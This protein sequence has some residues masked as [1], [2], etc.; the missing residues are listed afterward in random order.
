M[1]RT[2]APSR[3]STDA[4]LALALLCAVALAAWLDRGRVVH[5]QEAAIFSA[6]WAGIEFIGHILGI[7][8]AAVASSLVAVVSYLST[9]VAW[10][11]H[12]IAD[13][14][15]STGAVFAKVWEG[16]KIVWS[17]VL[18]PALVWIDKSITRLATWLKDTLKPVFKWLDTVR[19]HLD[20]IYKRFVRPI[21]DTIDFVRNV[22]RVLL[23]FHITL[24]QKL[25]SVLA[26][27]EQRIEE[28]ILWLYA[29]LSEVQNAVNYVV[30]ADGFFQRYALLRSMDKYAPA[31]MK[32]FWDKQV[33]GLSGQARID[34]AAREVRER[35][36]AEYG[37]H[38]SKIY[39]GHEG[40]LSGYVGE[41][42]PLWKDA[43]GLAT[44][45][46]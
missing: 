39:S 10:L 42:V 22:N 28:P 25:D 45:S 1:R 36:A 32:S 3:T 7:V 24:L 40:E 19:K 5:V 13:V 44:P 17:D 35:P 27:I 41:L 4:V 23:T 43:A 2:S 26:Q 9:A 12:R 16:L 8:G 30:T 31:W 15:F 46:L 34:A 21:I 14:V 29:R 33:I 11:A 38:L 6:I 20:D 37:T 18:K